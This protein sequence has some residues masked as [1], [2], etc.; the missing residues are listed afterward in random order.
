MRPVHWKEVT[1]AL[2]LLATLPAASQH[3]RWA[4]RNN[5]EYDRRK[6]TYGF[7]IGIHNSAYQI[8]YANKFITQDQDTVH[9]VV[10]DFQGGFSLG[11]LINLRLHDMLDIRLMPKAGFYNHRLAYN[12]TNA[13]TKRQLVET[14]MVEL[15]L[16]LKYKSMRRGNVRM[17][18]VGGVTPAFE[19]SGKKEVESTSGQ[20][21]IRKGNLSLDGGLGFDFYFP[22]FKL[23]QEIRYSRGVLNI[24]GDYASAYRQPI[25]SISTNTISVY[26]IFQ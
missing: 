14:T 24:L 3:Y 22:L 1:L 4:H 12:F 18:M 6:F 10:P 11:F 17:Y 25:Q 5:P 21:T 20:L 2:L 7:S 16:L 13:P 19:A 8:R 23:S 26:F 9:S 15:P